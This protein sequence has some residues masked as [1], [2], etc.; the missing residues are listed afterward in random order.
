MADEKKDIPGFFDDLKGEFD[1]AQKFISISSQLEKAATEVNNKFGQTKERIV[2]IKTSIVDA[3]PEIIRL[4]GDINSVQN[5]IQAIAESSRRNVVATTEQTEKLFAASKVTGQ[6]IGTL[7]NR[8]T[9]VGVGLGQMGKQIEGSVNFVRSIG[10]NTQEVFKV[11]TANMDQLNRFQFEGGV[12]G[13]TKMAAQASMLRFDMGEALRLADRVLDPEGAVNMAAAFQRLGVS[14]GNLADPFQLMNESINDPSGIQDSL[15]KVSKQFTYFDE[16][17]KSFKINPQ[18]V[19]T[20]REME[21]QANLTSGSLSK[22][23]LA[24]AELDARLSDVSR[25]G[26]KFENEEDKQYLAN[27]AKMGDGGQYEVKINDTE[28]VKLSELT[29]QE[30][31]KLIKEQKE[32]PKTL[33][34][35]AKGQLTVFQSVDNNVKSIATAIAGGAA[36][37]PSLLQGIA[38]FDRIAKTVTG[39]LAKTVKPSESRKVTETV[40]QDFEGLFKD[41]KSGKAMNLSLA[42]FADKIN[43]QSKNFEGDIKKGL[44]DALERVSDKLGKN[45]Y[46]EALLKD[47]TTKLTGSVGGKVSPTTSNVNKVNSVSP[48]YNNLL[49]DSSDTL[50]KTIGTTT[51][52]KSQVDFAGGLKIDVKFTGAENF[53]QQQLEQFTRIFNDKMNSTEVQTLIRNIRTSNNPTKAP[54]STSIGNK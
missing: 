50:N 12:V 49:G 19:L 17:T 45:T 54:L 52:T 30:F 41:I 6:E 38:G 53:S 18:G 4:G 20:L 3:L 42:D 39:E 33:E 35:I 37:S 9:D 23:G 26:I 10:G 32:G 27:I 21:K 16:K 13:L 43:S 48:I 15:A 36:T 11:V 24:A 1:L 2:E 8:F 40:I 46:G 44:V 31:N 25:A 22:M 7:V 5:E 34:D 47:L 14:V 29:Q 28:T 51:S